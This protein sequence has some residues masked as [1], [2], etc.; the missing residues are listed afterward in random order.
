MV[1]AGDQLH[2]EAAAVAPVHPANRRSTV[3][4]APRARRDPPLC[5]LLR[6][7][8]RRTASHRLLDTVRHAHEPAAAAL[9]KGEAGLAAEQQDAITFAPRLVCDRY[10]RL[11][12]RVDEDANQ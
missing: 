7:K 5:A 3:T 9:D 4:R 12:Q 11:A 8:H 2:R 10:L 1:R 6:S